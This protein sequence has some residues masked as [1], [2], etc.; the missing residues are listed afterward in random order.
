VG[1]T[2]FLKVDLPGAQVVWSDGDTSSSR[3]ITTAGTYAVTVT[4]GSCQPVSDTLRVDFVGEPVLFRSDEISACYGLPYKLEVASD[5]ATFSWSDGNEGKNSIIIV[6][7][8]Y[9]SVTVT[10]ACGIYEDTTY[11]RFDECSSIIYVPNAFTPDGDGLNDCFGV[12]TSNLDEFSLK[13]YSRWGQL[14]YETADPAA[15]WDG[16]AGGSAAPA[17]VY[18]WHIR[19]AGMGSHISEREGFRSGFVY[20]L[21]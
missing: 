21:R 9:Y 8:G 14:L 4:T 18:A 3:S 7:D 12:Q 5:S 20:L 11:V 19:Y 2:L 16:M 15:C 6:S 1:E 17:G 10:N 13:I